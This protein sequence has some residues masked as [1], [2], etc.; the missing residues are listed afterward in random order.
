MGLP[1]GENEAGRDGVC[2]LLFASCVI[3]WRR[4]AARP[5]GRGVLVGAWKQQRRGIPGK[6]GWGLRPLGRVREHWAEGGG[7]LQRC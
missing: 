4:A 6:L 5:C 3:T 1:S 2:L 7:S